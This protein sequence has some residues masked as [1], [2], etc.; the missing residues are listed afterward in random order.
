[1]CCCYFVF[2][3]VVVIL[4]HAALVLPIHVPLVRF[5]YDRINGKNSVRNIG[6]RSIISRR[7][8]SHHFKKFI[9]SWRQ[10]NTSAIARS[11]DDSELQANTT[12]FRPLKFWS[13]AI[14]IYGF[15]L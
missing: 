15:L 6:S 10:A 14:R 12:Q 2:V 11:Q 8:S 3:V 5:Y 7:K 1:M 9:W 4:L 13:R